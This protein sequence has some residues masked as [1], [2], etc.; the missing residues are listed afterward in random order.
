VFGVSRAVCA[1]SVN[2]N[3]NAEMRMNMRMRASC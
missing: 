1:L 3:I 2:G